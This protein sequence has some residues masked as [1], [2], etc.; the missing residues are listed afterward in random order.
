MITRCGAKNKKCGKS[1]GAYAAP[2]VAAG[3]DKKPFVPFVPF[4]KKPPKDMK[5][6]VKMVV[7]PKSKKK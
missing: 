6:D 7:K 4:G 1:G 3:K 5:A 2:T